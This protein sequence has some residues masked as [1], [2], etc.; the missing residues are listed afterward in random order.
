MKKN[1]NELLLKY[2]DTFINNVNCHVQ[3]YEEQKIDYYMFTVLADISLEKYRGQIDV[4]NDL[5]Y[6]SYEVWSHKFDVATGFVHD[7]SRKIRKM[8]YEPK[9]SAIGG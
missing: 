5:G 7:W 8:E 3:Q 6:I 4:L 2:Y 1:V 9:K